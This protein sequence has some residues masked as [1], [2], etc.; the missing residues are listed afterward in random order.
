MDGIHQDPSNWI[1][2]TVFRLGQA[3]DGKISQEA[4][5]GWAPGTL[6]A[7]LSWPKDWLKNPDTGVGYNSVRHFNV[8]ETW[9][10]AAIVLRRWDD[11]GAV[12]R[13]IGHAIL[14]GEPAFVQQTLP[15]TPIAL[16]TVCGPRKPG[17]GARPS[18]A[19]GAEEPAAKVQRYKAPPPHKVQQM[20]AGAPPA[21]PTGQTRQS[22][23]PGAAAAGTTSKSGPKAPP[24]T[25]PE[26]AEP[27]AASDAQPARLPAG[28]L[29]TQTV[30]AA[31]AAEHSTK[32]ETT[33]EAKLEV[34]PAPNQLAAV[35]EAAKVLLAHGFTLTDEQKVA[36]EAQAKSESA[37]EKAAPK[38]WAGYRPGA[39][40]TGAGDRSGAASASSW[41]A[42]EWAQTPDESGYGPASEYH[43]Y[44]R[45]YQ[46]GQR[47]WNRQ[48][49]TWK[50][51]PSDEG[52]HS[53]PGGPDKR[54][55]GNQPPDQKQTRYSLRDLFVD[56]NPEEVCIWGNEEK[57]EA[58]GRPGAR[59]L[60]TGNWRKACKTL[61]DTERV[62]IKFMQNSGRLVNDKRGF[63]YRPSLRKLG[64]LRAFI[65]QEVDFT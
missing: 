47:G 16:D 64:R 42:T 26:T 55:R 7:L 36:V 33:A 60:A 35:A 46:A 6:V 2:D 23:Q 59:A 39:L 63:G 52:Y 65:D 14:P 43:P 9:F 15:P 12:S 20:E 54:E 5:G 11:L 44:H 8:L 18:T 41:Q 22:A 48:P 17:P 27:I 50:H 29:A 32:Q 13:A 51:A 62:F 61:R 4:T 3:A 56:S 1:L 38:Q 10:L 49:R 24:P 34:T 21:A 30:A 31:P 45:Q 53:R 58:L 28:M 37:T 19:T 40:Q 57:I 25:L